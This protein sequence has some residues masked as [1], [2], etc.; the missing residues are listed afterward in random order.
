MLDKLAYY[1]KTL[2]ETAPAIFGIRGTFEQPAYTVKAD[3][4]HGLE[5]R[6]YAPCVS[7]EATIAAPTQREASETAFRLLFAY[8]AGANQGR[9]TIAMTTPVQQASTL[10]AMT[11]PVRVDAA[12][13]QRQTRI[14]MRFTLPTKL[15]TNP[16]NPTDPRV[17]LVTEPAKTVAALR[18]TGNPTETA[19]AEHQRTLLRRLESLGWQTTGKPYALNYDPP[20]AIP[21]LKRN[22]VVV[23]VAHR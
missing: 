10:I 16:P 18:Y 1:A 7:A 8:I 6:D 20:F 17:T 3:L 2:A 23:E 12:P 21:F 15:A 11:T 5:I 22:E 19:R 9:Q 13:A 4:E 14:G